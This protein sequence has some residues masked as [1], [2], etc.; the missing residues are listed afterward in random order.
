MPMPAAEPG[1]LRAPPAWFAAGS[2]DFPRSLARV[3]VLLP[4]RAATMWVALDQWFER[5]ALHPRIVGEFDDSAMLKTFGAG[6]MG[7]FPAVDW[8]HDDLVARFGVRRIGGSLGLE[9]PFF[10]IAAD[11]RIQHS[12]VQRLWT[13][14]TVSGR[15]AT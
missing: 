6:G 5:E 2:E 1:V 7:V 12:L 13:E 15:R 3:P 4:T 9:E 8:V 14:P 11:K 10:A